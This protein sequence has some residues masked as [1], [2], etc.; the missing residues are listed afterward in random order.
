MSVRPPIP[1]H[2]EQ[3]L[4]SPHVRQRGFLWPKKRWVDWL[5]A[6]H[7]SAQILESLPSA[8][9]R[10]T[11][12]VTVQACIQ[13]EAIPEAFIA[14]M[15]WGHGHS[16]YGPFRTARILSGF[17]KPANQPVD[18]TV[19]N[20]LRTSIDRMQTDGPVD[21]YR[22]LNNEG[23]VAGF[24]PAFFTKWLYFISAADDPYGAQAAPALDQLVTRWLRD[25]AAVS[26]RYGRTSDYARYVELLDQWG[27]AHKRTQV[28]V[29][30][31][32]FRLIRND[33][34]SSED[35]Q[36]GEN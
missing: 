34:I 2:L 12:A 36:N 10:I 17:S 20:R 11:T 23:H 8:V 13:R 25:N 31:A 35:Q 28:Q 30:E 14:C 26:L 32:I 29:E 1:P 27:K 18:P 3:L 9:D 16:G 21:A 24:G 22:Y 5:S 7:G 15:V 4:A 19:V 6:I 33:G